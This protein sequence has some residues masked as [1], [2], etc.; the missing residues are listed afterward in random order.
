[1]IKLQTKIALQPEKHQIDYASKVL[2]LG[3]CFATNIGEKFDYFKFQHLVNPFGISFHP[4]AIETLVTRAINETYF[5]EDD[6][7]YHN[8]Q[9]CC[10]E[11]HSAL[12]VIEKEV[13]LRILNERLIQLNEYI[14]SA[15]HIIFT[16]GTSWVY[17]FI[18]TD[19]IV[20]NCYKVPQKKFL[21][22][23]LS[24][25][26][27]SASIDNVII[28]IQS[29][30][31]EVNVI[32]TVSPV[33]H[34]KDGLLENTR[35][36]AQLITGLHKE[37]LSKNR[38]YYFPSYEIM[39]D[40]L[41]DYRFYKEDLIHPNNTAISIIWEAFKEVWVSSSTHEIQKEISTIQRGLLH[42]PFNKES[43]E[44]QK[45]LK[46]IEHKI[47]SIQSKYPKINF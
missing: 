43:L 38:I 23:L 24:E 39:M 31:S 19:S 27:I 16:Y 34:I 44:Y 4:I 9:W 35:S 30:N 42:K 12:S 2:L 13:Y 25:E 15:S 10:F 41:R 46:S 6:I 5:T 36:K 3:S 40:E 28:L 45:F 32:T 1:M 33:R 20:A 14:K 26:D 37:V 21:K 11:A 17:R 29:V 47:V 8:E 18:E 22:E 7:F